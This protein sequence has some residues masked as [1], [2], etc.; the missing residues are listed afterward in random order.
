MFERMV[1]YKA[2][3]IGK[4]PSF[5]EDIE[6]ALVFAG[7]QANSLGCGITVVAPTKDRFKEGLLSRLPPAVGQETPKTLSG[8]SSQAEP[9]VVAC[10]PGAKDL[11][12][13]D[14]LIGLKVL[15]VVPW[16]EGRIEVWRA[17]RAAVDLL[18]NRPTASKPKIADS[19]VA[20]AMKDLTTSVNLSTGLHHPDDRFAA[21]QALRILKRHKRHI[22]ADEIQTWA[23]ANGW[24]AEDARQLG[25][26]VRGVLAGKAYKV[27]PD[28]W[29]S[30]IM[31]VWKE[32]AASSD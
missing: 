25:D 30:D 20:Q 19:V 17:A 10:W 6:P 28:H 15:I 26:F 1:T 32:E 27:G 18:G 8:Y 7:E 4:F 22:D 9:V 2:F 11:D 12:Q 24:A 3:Y 16:D 5:E 31:A 13:L 29:R 14:A 23:M 21:I